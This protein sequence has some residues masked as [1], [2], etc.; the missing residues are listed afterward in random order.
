MIYIPVIGAFLEATGMI[1]S[2]KI[3]KNKKISSNNYNVYEFLAITLVLIPFMLFLFKV[4]PGALDFWNIIIM[5]G[6]VVVSVLANILVFYAVK[7]DKVSALE[8]IWVMQPLFT[9]IL[10]FIFFA[11]ER[12]VISLVLA[13]VASSA[14]VISHMK[15]SHIYFNKY[16][17]AA[18]AGSFL[19]ALELILSNLILKYYTGL[20]FYFIRCFLVF[21]ICYALFRPNGKELNKNTIL[22]L[23]AIGFVWIGNRLIIYWGYAKLGVIFTTT[24]FILS[25]VLMF[26]FAVIFLKEKPKIKQIV[27]TLIIV[28]CVVLSMMLRN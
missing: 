8:P 17:I 20:T 16:A 6:V 19:F 2:K 5:L 14:L 28:L 11:T 15:K 23:I 3:L 18:A 9:I 10:A 27:A 21:L 7:G 4:Y 1:F 24:V 25:P 12:N 22:M 13:L 26:L